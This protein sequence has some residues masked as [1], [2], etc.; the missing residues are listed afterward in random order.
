MPITVNLPDGSRAQFPDGT[1]KEV[2]KAAIQ[3]KLGMT[4]AAAPAPVGDTPPPGAKPGSREY[5]QWALQ[6][7]TSGNAVPQVGPAPIEYQPAAP[8]LGTAALDNLR[9]YGYSTMHSVPFVGDKIAGKFNEAK[10]AFHNVPLADVEAQHNQLREQNPAA[11]IAGNIVGPT[12][13]L[14][15]LGATAL[16]A[17][18]LGMSGSLGSRVGFGLASGGGITFGDALSRGD[19]VQDAAVKGLVGAGIGVALPALGAGAQKVFQAVTRSGVPRP[20]AQVSKALRREGIDAQTLP[21]RMADLGPEGML[22]DLGPNLTR[23]ASTLASL[24]GRAQGIVRGRLTERAAG[25][26]QRVRDTLDNELGPSPIPSLEKASIRAAQDAL[27]PH[28]EAVLQRGQPVNVTS[29][30]QNIAGNIQLLRGEPQRVLE[31]L[32]PMLN[33]HGTN[34]LTTS[35][36]VLFEVRKAIDGM[37]EGELT[38]QSRAVL[39]ATRQRIDAEL[40]RAVPGIK[41]VDGQFAELASQNAAIDRGGQVLSNGPEAPW[42][43][44]LAAEV[45]GASQGVRQRL[46]QGTR[47]L[48]ERI[49]GNNANDV[50]ALNRL[51]KGEG[52]WNRDRLV[53]L[54]GPERTD[55]IIRAIQNEITF[56]RTNNI[57]QQGPETAARLHGGQELGEINMQVPAGTTWTGAIAGAGAKVLNKVM[58]TDRSE[59]NARIA[60]LLTMRGLPPDVE[61]ALRRA[62]QPRRN[63][64]VPPAG[65]AT[66][67]AGQLPLR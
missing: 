17:R 21:T 13:A 33:E 7:A 32:L 48:L 57:V 26:N 24:P 38:T 36:R 61:S 3:K 22:A 40:A 4:A 55:R 34:Q 41:Q 8:D 31:R 65:V 11:S 2:M 27:S 19:N 5:A 37:F 9:T 28:Y 42:P 46:S 1:S 62:M 53:T 39:T 12:A 20:V 63:S 45:A 54:F 18:L 16:G 66:G 51:I 47:A 64:L 25:A 59:I 56:S 10:A 15:P 60:E 44:D 58:N 29:I 50:Q 49:V 6:R 43:A 52:D 14:A 67:V 35:P 30:A 23:Q